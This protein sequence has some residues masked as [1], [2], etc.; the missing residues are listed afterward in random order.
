MEF[1]LPVVPTVNSNLVNFVI[2]MISWMQMRNVVGQTVLIGGLMASIRIIWILDYLMSLLRDTRL[3]DLRIYVHHEL[4][5]K[6]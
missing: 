4:Q 6:G 5:E 2:L 1:P 3:L